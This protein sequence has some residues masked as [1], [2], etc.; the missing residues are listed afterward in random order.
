MMEEQKLTKQIAT[1]YYNVNYGAK[2]NFAS[3]D[4]CEKLPS[5]ISMA[6]LSFGILA[7]GFAEFNSK[8]LGAALLIIGIAGLLLKP[9]EA[10]K[11]EYKQAGEKLIA[12]SKKIKGNSW[13][14]N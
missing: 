11:E 14:V 3:Y 8:V 2:M 4:I 9:R 12:L 6:S 7:L 10:M 13:R 1:E 5:V